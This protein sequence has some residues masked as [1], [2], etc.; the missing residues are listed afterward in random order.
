MKKSL[1]KINARDA[2]G[3]I[4]AHDMTRIVPGKFKGAGFKTCH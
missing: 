3:S 1:I 2:A 4:L